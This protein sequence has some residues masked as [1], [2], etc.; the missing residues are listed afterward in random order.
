MCEVVGSVPI[1]ARSLAHH[2]LISKWPS[3]SESGLIT[4]NDTGENLSHVCPSLISKTFQST[5]SHLHPYEKCTT[6]AWCTCLF[7]LIFGRI[8]FTLL[9]FSFFQERFLV[10]KFKCRQEHEKKLMISYN[11]L[12]HYSIVFLCQSVKFPVEIVNPASSYYRLEPKHE[13]ARN[14]WVLHGCYQQWI[15][16]ESVPWKWLVMIGHVFL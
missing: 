11:S 2:H 9:F 3:P 12:A 15:I 13:S 8:A 7:F 14:I 4:I 6:W 5:H 10:E 1:V 16:S